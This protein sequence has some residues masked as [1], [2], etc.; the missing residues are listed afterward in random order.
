[1]NQKIHRVSV[2]GTG[3]LGTMIAIQAASRGYEVKTYDL[4]PESFPK[5]FRNIQ[6][7]LKNMGRNP[8]PPFAAWEEGANRVQPC[9]NLQ[10]ALKNADLVIEAIVENLAR[11]R[12]LFSQI[13]LLSPQQA[14]LATNSSSL[15]ISKIES[16]TNRPEK[17]L[18]MHFYMAALGQNMV[19]IMGGTRTTPETLEV[20]I[21]WIRSLGCV[22]LA[23][24][25][26]ILGFCFN[27]IWRAIKR[28][29]LFMWAGGYVD[30][31]DIDRAWMIFSGMNLG[32][33]G[34]MDR[35][36]LDVIYDIEMI[37]FVESR[38]PKDYPPEALKAMIE[39]KELGVK[40]GKG[41]YIYPQPE[42]A[43]SD[44]LKD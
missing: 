18:N 28:Q 35:V 7:F 2:V 21:Q 27:S 13:D 22:P 10:V 41:F 15:P 6:N 38:D 23:V 11:K 17:C 16:A 9:P 39:R 5:N 19:D 4:D 32:P 44:F 40:T 31:R 25:K 33:F 12:E 20:G 24:Q 26:E 30:F 34:L 42:Y 3:T 37:Y 8:I 36:G 1:M 29:S 14:I 43:Q